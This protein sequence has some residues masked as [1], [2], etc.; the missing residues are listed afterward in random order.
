MKNM[1]TIVTYFLTEENYSLSNKKHSTIKM[2]YNRELITLKAHIS[3]G[4]RK[5][6]KYFKYFGIIPFS[7]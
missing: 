4:K 7:L 1:A 2:F 3:C 6:L 5:K